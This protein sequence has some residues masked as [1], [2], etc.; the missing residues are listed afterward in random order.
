MK[1]LYRTKNETWKTIQSNL[2]FIAAA[3]L[4]IYNGGLLIKYPV[5]RE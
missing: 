5:F 2:L 4:L 3:E 1:D